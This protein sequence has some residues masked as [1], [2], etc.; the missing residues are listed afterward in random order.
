VAVS[1]Q[2]GGVAVSWRPSSGDAAAFAVYRVEAAEA[3]LVGTVR[4][5]GSA[6]Q[7]WVDP[8]PGEATE[9][10]V[11]ALDRSWNEGNLSEQSTI[12]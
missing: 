11:S 6:E 3:K 1:R 8:A 2:D 4:S 10:C 7:T 12:D 5:T 9:Y